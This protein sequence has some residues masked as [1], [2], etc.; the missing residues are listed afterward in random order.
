MKNIQI[1]A[2]VLLALFQFN[3]KDNKKEDS[4]SKETTEIKS[5]SVKSV[6]ETKNF[7]TIID[8]KKVN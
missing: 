4:V 3:C 1:V 8:G 2:V 6:L 5:D 7:D